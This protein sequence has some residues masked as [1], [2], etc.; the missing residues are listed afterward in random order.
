MKNKNTTYFIL[1]YG[2]FFTYAVG[3]SILGTFMVDFLNDFGMDVSE[4][5]IFTVL[6]NTGCLAGVI[7][8]A[9]VLKYFQ[10][11]IWILITYGVFAL[12]MLA[13][14]RADTL[15]VFLILL[16]L[17]GIATKFLDLTVN[18]EISAYHDCLLYTSRCV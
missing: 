7:V 18:T 8:S 3:T 11:R 1:I 12:G 13:V 6:Y 5:G 9:F 14:S 2:L 15:T 17:I 10:N 4:G 16:L